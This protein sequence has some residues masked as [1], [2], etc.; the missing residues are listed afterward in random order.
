ME[1]LRVINYNTKILRDSLIRTAS[2]LQLSSY[3]FCIISL[4]LNGR[5]TTKNIIAL[6]CYL[7]PTQKAQEKYLV[8]LKTIF[9]RTEVWN[10]YYLSSLCFYEC[11]TFLPSS[12]VPFHWLIHLTT[13]ITLIKFRIG[14]KYL[15]TL[16]ELGDTGRAGK[17]SH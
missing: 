5:A 3:C 15:Y 2:L 12:L 14:A 8:G 17:W 9:R 4:T 16:H 10:W 6:Q 11:N 13:M 1:S 7:I